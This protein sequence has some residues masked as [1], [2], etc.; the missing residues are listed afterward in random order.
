MPKRNNTIKKICQNCWKEFETYWTNVKF[1]SVNCKEYKLR[2]KICEVC[3]KEY[4]TRSRQ[5]KYCSPECKKTWKIREYENTCKQ[6]YWVKN[7][8]QVKWNRDKATA[9]IKE[10]FWEEWLHSEEI[11]KRKK[12]SCMKKYWVSSCMKVEL[13]KNK[14]KD[15]MNKKYWWIWMW[16]NIIKE[17]IIATNNKKYWVSYQIQTKKA[18]SWTRTL[19]A[20][21]SLW[22]KLLKDYNPQSEFV[23]WKYTYDIKVW[24]TLID[25]NPFPYHNVTWHPYWKQLSKDYHYKRTKHAIDNWYRIINVFDRDDPYKIIDLLYNWN[26]IDLNLDLCLCK[27]LQYKD[28]KDFID[29][30]Y[31]WQY[32]NKDNTLYCW[33]YFKEVLI[34]VM[35]FICINDRS[36]ELSL[37]CYDKTINIYPVLKILYWYFTW[38]KNPSIVI[39][40]CDMSK[41]DWS[42]YDKLW[43]EFVEWI[44]PKCHKYYI[45]NDKRNDYVDIYDCWYTKYV[46][47][48]SSK[49]TWL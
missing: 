3:W 10:R 16:S 13:I 1:C 48:K 34:A 19:S 30:L 29:N 26:K 8:S 46:W 24:N 11:R 12:E 27:E 41:Y 25:I 5:Q 43:F 33:F 20:V 37:I 31:V 32:E 15:T 38:L 4:I 2:N 36:W 40:Y 35:W 49:S 17:K 47:Y 44:D 6:K 21:N 22:L 42:I 28:C 14:A 9:T 7:I 23:L 45:H 39:S 18:R